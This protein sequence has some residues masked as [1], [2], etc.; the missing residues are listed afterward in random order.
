M[1]L[2]SCMNLDRMQ[3]VRIQRLPRV[4]DPGPGLVGAERVRH[5]DFR[6]SPLAVHIRYC[7]RT[8]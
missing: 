8:Q 5:V 1:I 2:R 6:D 7:R 3:V 4:R